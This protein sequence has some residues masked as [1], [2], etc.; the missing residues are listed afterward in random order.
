MGRLLTLTII[1]GLGFWFREPIMDWWTAWR[2]SEAQPTRTWSTPAVVEQ[3]PKI[4]DLPVYPDV[5]SKKIETL[6]YRCDFI[7]IINNGETVKY[8]VRI[9]GGRVYDREYDPDNPTNVDYGSSTAFLELS[10]KETPIVFHI[11]LTPLPRS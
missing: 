5:W 7:P 6:G 9:N 1:G 11:V 10:S 8:Q 4:E 3:N 2:E